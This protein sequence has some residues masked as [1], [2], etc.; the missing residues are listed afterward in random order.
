MGFPGGSDSRE[1]AC[2]VWDPGSIPG[3]GRSPGEE[4]GNPLQYSCL[5][6]PTERGAWWA[7]VPEVTKSQTQLSDFTF[8]HSDNLECLQARMALKNGLDQW[9]L[10][11]N[12]QDSERD[13][14][15]LDET[16]K[17]DRCFPFLLLSSLSKGSMAG[18]AEAMWWPWGSKKERKDES[19]KH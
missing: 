10:I 15:S 3:L 1:S 19:Q 5:G 18:V 11:D 4:N 9:D 14:D 12:S 17:H 6:N 16:E 2:S 13:F 8:T 7:T